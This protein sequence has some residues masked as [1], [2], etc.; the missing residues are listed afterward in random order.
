MRGSRNLPW[1]FR[2]V[3]VR[4]HADVRGRIAQDDLRRRDQSAAER[5]LDDAKDDQREQRRCRSTQKRGDREARDA[6]PN[7][8]TGPVAPAETVRAESRRRSR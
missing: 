1:P 3:G 8:A 2:A 5:A 7:T 4:A 6:L